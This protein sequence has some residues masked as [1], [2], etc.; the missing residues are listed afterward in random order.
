MRLLFLMLLL[1]NVAYVAWELYYPKTNQH[2]V[3]TQDPGVKRLVLLSELPKAPKALPQQEIKAPAQV[4]VT[5]KP[6]A[7]PMAEKTPEH[8]PAETPQAEP[9]KKA[10]TPTPA[11][12][13]P[14]APPKLV[15]PAFA[16]YT[17]GPFRHLAD[18]RKLTRRMHE[19]V[20]EASYRSHEER[21]QSVYWVYLPQQK[22]YEVAKALGE[23]LK[24]KNI[25]D[26]YVIPKGD[27]ANTVSLGYFKDNKGALRV[28]KK[29]KAAGFPAEIQPIFKTYTVYWLDY[30]VRTDS[31]IPADV[32][33]LSK[34]PNVSRLDRSC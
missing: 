8:K 27:Q 7:E 5:D 10:N 11:P 33:D 4:V 28:Q 25:R 14:P 32:L 2:P 34:L 30:R 1:A 24:S 31:N 26:F 13:S 21:E 17:L 3:V 6:K 22:S 12:T 29:A 23:K 15:Q 20:A 18:L 19:Y 16:C 9:V